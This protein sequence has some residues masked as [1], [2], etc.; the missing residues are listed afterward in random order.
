MK[1]IADA[2]TIAEISRAHLI[3]QWPLMF[4]EWLERGPPMTR[5]A[6]VVFVMIPGG[7]LW[8]LGPLFLVRDVAMPDW[9]GYA[10]LAA[11]FGSYLSFVLSL[12]NA[13]RADHRP[14][15]FFW[16]A[17]L[18]E[19]AVPPR[20]PRAR[21]AA[22]GRPQAPAHRRRAATNS[23]PAPHTATADERSRV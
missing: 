16:L 22:R 5:F 9:L 19:R 1:H 23:L 6:K 15:G 13:M 17:A 11:G 4:A 7:F 12:V 10:V 3:S 20:S 8:F 21:R 14:A 2:N 18:I